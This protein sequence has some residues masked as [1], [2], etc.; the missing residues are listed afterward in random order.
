MINNLKVRLFNKTLIA[1]TVCGSLFAGAASAGTIVGTRHDFTQ[2]GWNDEGQICVFCHVPH[3]ADTTV[4]NVPLWNHE[5]TTQTY[6]LYDSP[7]FDGV[8][9]QGQ[10]GSNS[11]LCL[12]CHD[13][14]VAVDSYGG[15]TGD[16]FLSGPSAVGAG[17]DLS[18][19]HPISF[20]YDTSL[21][22][23][24]GSL[25]DPASQVVTI[26]SGDKS[27]TGTLQAVLL[28]DDRME[29][30]SCH[31]VHN[32][33]TQSDPLLKIDSVGSELCLA[34]HDK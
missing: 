28:F 18:D 29:C 1:A 8:A 33:F 22:L 32:T 12:S 5:L 19:D 14:T 17:G 27:R 10:P 30:A 15:S 6:D 26:G 34:C 9:T 20:T 25:H 3:N 2:F 4:T 31:D 11:I 7:T 23:E 21:S 13:G 24:D 16:F